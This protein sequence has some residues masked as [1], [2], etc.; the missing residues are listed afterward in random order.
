VQVMTKNLFSAFNFRLLL[1]L[2]AV[3]WM[4]AFFLAPLAGLFWWPT[5]LPGLIVML[6]VGA[7]YRVMG[8]VSL[9][10]A[11]YAWLYPLGTTV[12]LWAMLQSVVTALWQGGVVWRGT[13]YALRDLRR[14]NSQFAWKRKN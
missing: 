3:G 8:E 2:G 7:C 6:C 14:H 10:D 1:L 13:K 4:I 11:R 5:L 9:I 12:F